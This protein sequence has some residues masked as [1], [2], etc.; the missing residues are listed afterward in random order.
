MKDFVQPGGAQP[1]LFAHVQRLAPDVAAQSHGRQQ[2]KRRADKGGG[3]PDRVDVKGDDQ[4]PDQRHQITSD[5]ADDQRGSPLRGHSVALHP[6]DQLPRGVGLEEPGVQRQKMTHKVDLHR[7]G[8][9]L[10]DPCQKPAAQDRG[11]CPQHEQPQD[12]AAN[13]DQRAGTTRG[14]DLIEQGLDHVG[15]QPKGRAFHRHQDKGQQHQGQ[16]GPQVAAPEAAEQL[17]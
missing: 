11:H 16:M 12:R 10:V 9:G 13:P 4:Q 3:G 7:P 17:A 6:F 5:T 1:G 14:K 15:Q 8:G 2:Q